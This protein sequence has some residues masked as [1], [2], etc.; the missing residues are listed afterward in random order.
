MGKRVLS[1]AR[2]VALTLAV[3][4]TAAP[5]VYA[6][7][8]PVNDAAKTALANADKAVKAKDWAKALAEFEAANKAQSSADA[9]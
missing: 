3:H 2:L 8:A 1:S 4:L 7:P 5:F 6:Q 9:L